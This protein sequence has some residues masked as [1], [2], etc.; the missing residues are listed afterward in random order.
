M[1]MNKPSS[2]NSLIAN[3]SCINWAESLDN[4]YI[5]RLNGRSKLPDGRDIDRLTKVLHAEVESMDQASL[6]SEANSEQ[7]LGPDT[8]YI[9]P[10][11][12]SCRRR[13][14]A[15]LGSGNPAQFIPSKIRQDTL[16]YT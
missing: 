2:N 1:G 13:H 3:C 16:G 11:F 5:T 6:K 12:L 15:C 7:P 9:D 14:W 4:I 8:A 10:I